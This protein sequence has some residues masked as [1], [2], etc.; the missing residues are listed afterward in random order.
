MARLLDSFGGPG[1]YPPKKFVQALRSLGDGVHSV[2]MAFF[3]SVVYMEHRVAP[4]SFD[5]PAIQ[6]VGRDPGNQQG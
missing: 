4:A 3:S 6:G 2:I 5:K 1:A